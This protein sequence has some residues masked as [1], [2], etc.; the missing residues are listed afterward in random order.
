MRSFFLKVSF[1]VVLSLCLFCTAYAV[2]DDL[3]ENPIGRVQ[4]IKWMNLR[5]EPSSSSAIITT[6]PEETECVVYE[7][8]DG[9]YK[10]IYNGQVGYL[11]MLS[12][13]L[14]YTAEIGWVQII[15]WMNLRSEPSLSSVIITEVPEG[16]EVP[17]YEELNGW[18]KVIYNGQIAYLMIS[19]EHQVYTSGHNFRYETSAGTSCL[20][21]TYNRTYCAFC[22]WEKIET[23]PA[24]GHDLTSGY[25]GSQDGTSFSCETGGIKSIWCKRDNCTY[26]VSE[27]IPPG[28]TYKE[29]SLVEPTYH[30]TGTQTMEC[31][32]CGHRD[33]ITI[34]MLV[35]DGMSAD[36]FS[37]GQTFLSGTWKLFGVYVPGFGFTFGGMLIGVALVG[38]SLSVINMVFGFG[39]RGAG[40]SAR[41]GSSNKPKISKERSNDEF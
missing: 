39:R 24:L 4:I 34:P 8:L 21:D 7:V 11:M 33:Y 13:N 30:S 19:S 35:D 2:E 41:S 37:L 25:F 23:I 26:R 17:V 27:E 6:V 15:G 31:E 40:V 20:E 38:L 16:A 10:V 1:C 18:F 29:V 28:H 22:K 36:I 12:S 3:S 5:S 32:R 9:W 14:V